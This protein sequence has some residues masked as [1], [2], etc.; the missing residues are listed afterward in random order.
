MVKKVIVVPHHWYTF[1][2]YYHLPLESSDVLP[3]EYIGSY[4]ES[5]LTQQEVYRCFRKQNIQLASYEK[6]AVDVDTIMFIDELPLK[7][8]LKEMHK[9]WIYFG[10][11]P[12]N[13][14]T[15][16]RT[17]WL[18]IISH[19]V[20]AVITSNSYGFRSKKIHRINSAILLKPPPD[21][22]AIEN[23]SKRRLACMIAKKGNAS[24][25]LG[26]LYYQRDLVANFFNDNKLDDDF[27]LYGSG[28]NIDQ[29]S[30]IYRG[31]IKEKKDAYYT[32]RFAFA[33]DNNSDVL[34]ADKLFDAL[35]YGIV[36]VGTYAENIPEQIYV[37]LKKFKDIESLY[38]F[39][40]SMEEKEWLG[41][42]KRGQDFLES[43]EAKKYNVDAFVECQSR[44]INEV[45]L[46]KDITAVDMIKRY[47]FCFIIE[48][49]SIKS[50][51][52][53]AY[54]KTKIMLSREKSKK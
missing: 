6:R 28:W 48:T 5:A 38:L 19:F 17:A 26:S 8:L 46:L 44:I 1:D 53:K 47:A 42:I 32:H 12:A 50:F 3:E 30:H 41:F 23:F 35:M 33:L 15:T 39:L 34:S 2:S 43:D 27:D 16:N 14:I 4:T 9:R 40:K 49:I 24:K 13:V 18:K 52:L 11:E 36:P 10:L 51:C 21:L 22:S 7:I 37:N 20:D 29:Y 54:N 45:M 25:K 31:P